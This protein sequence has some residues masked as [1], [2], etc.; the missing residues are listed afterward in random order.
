V[1][2]VETN[3]DD[4]TT[5]TPEQRNRLVIRKIKMRRMAE[6][7]GLWTDAD[8]TAENERLETEIAAFPV[9]RCPPSG[10]H[11]SPTPRRDTSLV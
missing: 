2:F 10:H 6:N 7:R 5:L 11:A 1:S 4:E 9:R 3:L 8:F